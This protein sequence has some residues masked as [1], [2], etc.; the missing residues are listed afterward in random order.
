MV[1]LQCLSVRSKRQAH[2]GE[3][4]VQH[5]SIGRFIILLL[6]VSQEKDS[7]FASQGY[8]LYIIITFQISTSFSLSLLRLWFVWVFFCIEINHFWE[9]FL[10][11]PRSVR[12]GWE[13]GGMSDAE[14]AALALLGTQDLQSWSIFGGKVLWV[15]PW[16][17]SKPNLI[18]W[19]RT[20]MSL[21]QVGDIFWYFD[22]T[23]SRT[24]VFSWN[25]SGNSFKICMIPKLRSLEIRLYRSFQVTTICL[26][27]RHLWVGISDKTTNQLHICFINGHHFHLCWSINIASF[28]QLDELEGPGDFD[29]S[30]LAAFRP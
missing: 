27:A 1:C 25:N 21:I 13:V 10:A 6:L 2:P 23:R 26:D 20:N 12:P 3:Q 14:V 18:K 4:K 15:A 11:R 7:N 8:L 30:L 29:P 5:T 24:V 19:W 17:P 16:H 22:C 28:R 9:S